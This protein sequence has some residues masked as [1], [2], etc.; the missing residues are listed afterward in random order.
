M[1]PALL[2]AQGKTDAASVLYKCFRIMCHQMPQRSFFLFGAQL[3]YPVDVPEGSGMLSIRE[4]AG[5]V[6]GL[7]DGRDFYG[8]PEMGY[9]M[10]VCQRDTA[11]FSA[12][13]V[14]CLIFS[15]VGK[16]LYTPHPLLLLL[17]G[18]VPIML[19]GCTQLLGHAFP[20]VFPARESTPLLRI[21]T[22]ALFGFCL[23]WY[24]FPLLE[25]SLQ[26]GDEG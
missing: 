23:C 24:L 1:L 12:M 13:A 2:M 4:A 20:R 19:D 25:R 7:A 22:G 26:E 8:T 3:Y 15:L 9:K 18:G 10:A 17:F 5:F 14:F 21:V 11:I 6:P 16:R